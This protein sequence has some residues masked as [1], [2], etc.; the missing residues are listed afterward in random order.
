MAMKERVELTGKKKATAEG[1]Q[2]ALL[3][4]I[5]TEHGIIGIKQLTKKIDNLLSQLE[6]FEE[7]I[8]DGVKQLREV[9]DFGDVCTD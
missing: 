3:V 9:Y 6:T 7:D 2:K 4:G 8:I 1:E 5:K